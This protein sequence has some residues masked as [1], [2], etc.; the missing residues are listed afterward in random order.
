MIKSR[1]VFTNVQHKPEILLFAL[2]ILV[3]GTCICQYFLKQSKRR[4]FLAF[5]RIE[6][7]LKIVKLEFSSFHMQSS[8]LAKEGGER[9][10]MLVRTDISDSRLQ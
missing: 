1:S 7:K 8:K 10:S 3:K 5:V 6:D 9:E 2:D 4:L